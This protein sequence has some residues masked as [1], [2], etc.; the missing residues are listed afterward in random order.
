MGTVVGNSLRRVLISAISGGAITAVRFGGALHEFTTLD[1]VLEDVAEI[2]LN[3][4]QLRIRCDTETEPDQPVIARI[5]AEGPGVVSGLDLLAPPGITIMNPNTHIARLERH[6]RLQIT[7]HI[8][9]GFGFHPSEYNRENYP[10]GVIRLDA[11]Y[12]PILNVRT[13]TTRRQDT[14]Q[15]VLEVETDGSIHPCEAVS[16]AAFL[17]N[18]HF[19]LFTHLP[20]PPEPPEPAVP[21]RNTHENLPLSLIIPS[22]ELSAILAEARLLFL[23]DLAGKSIDE[24]RQIRR[25]GPKRLNEIRTVLRKFGLSPELG[26]TQKHP[27][28]RDASR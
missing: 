11:N 19:S 9:T 15:L 13:Q 26:S 25:I 4:K 16:R 28:N 1:G 7:L 22:E 24:L 10:I 27:E 17:L 3:L 18:A 2:I 8:E 20:R 12:S 14:E 5:D 21:P 23:N 6:A